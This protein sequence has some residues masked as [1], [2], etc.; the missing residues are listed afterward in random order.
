MQIEL[1]QGTLYRKARNVRQLHFTFRN[2]PACV[3]H[4]L[5][6]RYRDNV[7]GYHYW[8][9]R[10]GYSAVLQLPHSCLCRVLRKV[11]Q[12][13]DVCI[14]ITP[15]SRHYTIR[16]PTVLTIR[17]YRRVSIQFST[18]ICPSRANRNLPLP[19]YSEARG[20]Q[21]EAPSLSPHSPNQQSAL[22][23]YMSNFHSCSPTVYSNY[24]RPNHSMG[25][26]CLSSPAHL[27]Y[28]QTV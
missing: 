22:M 16:N 6:P 5:I 27:L 18:T 15:T 1:Q 24:V 9:N 17:Y 19:P 25:E 8:L 14:S 26:C 23:H 7:L 3:V 20:F 28:A 11:R 2:S 21:S 10:N 13:C 12:G 4:R